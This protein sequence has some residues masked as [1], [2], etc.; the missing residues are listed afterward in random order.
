MT[1]YLP[2]VDHG[3]YGPR[4]PD[5]AIRATQERRVAMGINVYLKGQWVTELP[6]FEVRPRSNKDG[7]KWNDYS[8]PGI[9]LN[10]KL[11]R[12]LIELYRL[13]DPIPSVLENLV[14]EITLQEW[15]SFYSRREA[16]IY[17]FGSAEAE[18]GT[19]KTYGD[20]NR[21]TVFI[22]SKKMDDLCELYQRLLVG[23]IR[24]EESYEGPQ[25]GLSRV[26]LEQQIEALMRELRVAQ[27]EAK[28]SHG[29]LVRVKDVLYNFRNRF[30]G[31]MW[32]WPFC[33]KRSVVDML[34]AII[35]RSSE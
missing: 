31:R 9:Y 28:E 13:T 34:T 32:M 20:M 26:E 3:S 10:Y 14:E 2:S 21:I 19:G 22:R 12:W 1:Q 33:T 5:E 25:G 15:V 4:K 6:G 11:G 35:S 27:C 24:P 18:V 17:R 23:S 8:L 30:D 29:R 7:Q 16:G